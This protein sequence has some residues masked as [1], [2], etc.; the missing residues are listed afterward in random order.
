ML[1]RML[2]PVHA[3]A[4][5][6]GSAVADELLFSSPVMCGLSPT[7]LIIPLCICGLMADWHILNLGFGFLPL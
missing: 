7:T 6:V 3:A 2:F 5:V 1:M 4:A